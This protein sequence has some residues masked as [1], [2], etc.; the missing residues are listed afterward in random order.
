MNIQGSTQKSLTTIISS[1]FKRLL[2]AICVVCLVG[3]SVMAQNNGGQDSAVQPMIQQPA[4]GG[5]QGQAQAFVQPQI[6]PYVQP[7]QQ[8]PFYFGMQIELRRDHWGRTTLKVVGVTPGS[9]AQMAGLEY[10]DEIRRVNGRGFR[11]ATDSFDAVRRLN[12]YV[13]SPFLGGPAPAAGAA[14]MVVG[15]IPSP[16]P[17]ARM[18]V[19]NVRNGRDVYVNVYPTRVSGGGGAPAVAAAM[20]AGG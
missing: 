20:S 9:P 1:Q 6:Q 10:G 16:S 8:N 18:V 13:S 3:S 17:I 12:S 5:Q 15:P 11:F 2:G 14:A 19:R 7:I 4:V